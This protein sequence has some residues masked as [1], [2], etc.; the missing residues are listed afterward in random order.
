MGLEL[1]LQ[2]SAENIQGRGYGTSAGAGSG[3]VACEG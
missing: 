1:S 3:R 2:A